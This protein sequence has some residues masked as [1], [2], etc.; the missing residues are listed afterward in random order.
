MPESIC[1]LTMKKKCLKQ[2]LIETFCFSELFVSPLCNS[3]ITLYPEIGIQSDLQVDSSWT[4]RLI[5]SP[6][7]TN[8]EHLGIAL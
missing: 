7:I 2:R 4:D 5:N 8:P 6:L 1:W 3:S